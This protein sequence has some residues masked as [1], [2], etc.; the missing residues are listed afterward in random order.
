MNYPD[1]GKRISETPVFVEIPN[2]NINKLSDYVEK[3]MPLDK[4]ILEIKKE[5]ESWLSSTKTVEEIKKGCEDCLKI[6]ISKAE[7]K[8]AEE[9]RKNQERK[10]GARS[11][12]VVNALKE[13]MAWKNLLNHLDEIPK[14]EVVGV[15]EGLRT[16]KVSECNDK[17]QKLQKKR[18]SYLPYGDSN[19]FI[20]EAQYVERWKSM[21]IF[22]GE[23]VEVSGRNILHNERMLAI[24]RKL[25]LDKLSRP[26]LYRP[27][28][29][30]NG[31]EHDLHP[32]Y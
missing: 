6:Y 21:C 30:E 14:T 28:V 20:K 22:F 27:F 24:F 19:L 15:T 32:G 3:I 26:K 31:K 11:D 7:S 1:N 2:P 13:L 9:I 23:P 12:D 17:I 16:A 25:G 10:A 29:D 8:L 4:E 5:R 18:K